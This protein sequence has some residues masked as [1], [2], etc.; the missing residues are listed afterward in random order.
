ML[1]LETQMHWVTFCFVLI[2]SYLFVS[3]LTI[4]LH[5]TDDRQRMYYLLLLG[6]LIVYNVTGGLF[7]DPKITF[8]SVQVQNSIAY[9]TGFLMASYFPYYFYK[10]FDLKLLRFHAIYGVPLFLLLPYIGFFVVA[11]SINNNLE[12]AIKYGVIVPFFYSMVLLWAILR[13]IRVAYRENRDMNYYLEEIA[14][15]CAIVPWASMT[16]IA[17]FHFSQLTE[18]LMTN[19]GFL[20]I[21]VMFIYKSSKRTKEENRMYRELRE[22]GKNPSPYFEENSVRLGLSKREAEVAQLIRQGLKNRAIA[23]KLHI[24]LSTVKS[25]V[26][27]LLRKTGAASR[28]EIIHKLIYDGRSE[29]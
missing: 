28:F 18:A 14:V 4:Y 8:I 6:L 16:L 2:E 24:S 26:E 29:N 9:G 22:I 21:T 10:A 1:F 27:S 11:Y 17:Y 19:V 15:Y 5:E 23:E 12:F 20:I 7:P 3:Q 13:A 25:H